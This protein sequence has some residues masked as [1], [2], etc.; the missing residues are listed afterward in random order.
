MDQFKKAT[1][2][3]MCCDVYGSRRKGH[4]HR[5]RSS[6]NFAERFLQLTV[7]LLGRGREVG[8]GI[9]TGSLN[10]RITYHNFKR[11]Q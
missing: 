7:E 1:W 8:V 5:I 10:I 9:H 11:Q 4:G 3:Q 2:V 6:V